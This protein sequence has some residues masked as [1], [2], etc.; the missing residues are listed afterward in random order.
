MTHTKT[1]LKSQLPTVMSTPNDAAVLI[2]R[3]AQHLST[4]KD[5]D[6][7]NTHNPTTCAHV[8]MQVSVLADRGQKRV[9]NL[10]VLAPRRAGTEGV[11]EE[12]ERGVLM[13]EPPLPVLAVHDLG[14]GRVQPQPDLDHPVPDRHHQAVRLAFGDAM[15]H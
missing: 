6:Q 7:S 5:D 12:R 3:V 8:P 2:Q 4:T 1:I 11:P 15:H 9:E 13:I 14:L 10:P